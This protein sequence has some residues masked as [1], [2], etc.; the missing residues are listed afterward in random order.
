MIL[1]KLRYYL[2]AWWR[3]S[4]VPF[5]S[6]GILP[7]ILG[8]VLAWR[9]GYKGP[10]G[11]Y[12]LSS[13]AV[14]LIMWMTYYLAERN[15]LEGDRINQDFNR[16]SGGSR[17]LVNGALPIWVPLL[18][19]YACLLAACLSGM[20]IYLHYQTGPWTLFL[21]GLGIFFGYFYSEKPFQWSYRGIGEILVGFCYGWLPIATGFYL[22][23]G[24][25]TPQVFLLSMPVSLS[26]FNVILINEF[27]DEEA[28]RAIGK[29]NL[30]V[31]FGKERM[32][33]FYLSLSVLVGLSFIKVLTKFDK[34]PFWIFILAGIPLTLILWSL[35]QIWRADYK[36]GKGLE[37]LC[38]NT[39]FVN[40]L[41]TMILTIQQTLLLS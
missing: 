19:G 18:L 32:G 1:E 21:G 25:F 41:I 39:L 6:V 35:I 17:I 12:L 3:L 40:L 24:F 11:L 16:F 23:T 5:L 4:R 29:R 14:I 33:E 7:L 30:V 10:L 37:V 36:T 31:R 22:F 15:D 34:T 2:I 9:W 8:F 13:G 28:D 27:P 26:I 20:T 38:R